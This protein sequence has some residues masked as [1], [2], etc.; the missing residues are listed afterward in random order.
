MIMCINKD[1]LLVNGV[2]KIKKMNITAIPSLVNLCEL[3]Q[4]RD[5]NRKQDL[6]NVYHK[7][8]NEYHALKPY[9]ILL[10]DATEALQEC[11]IY[12][13]LNMLVA[14]DEETEHLC[15]D[16]LKDVGKEYD[17]D[18][19]LVL[20]HE[21]SDALMERLRRLADCVEGVADKVGEFP[22]VAG[23]ADP[24]GHLGQRPAGDHANWRSRRLRRPGQRPGPL[25]GS[26]VCPGLPRERDL[27]AALLEHGLQRLPDV[28]GDAHLALG[29]GVDA[30]GQV[31][32]GI[33]EQV[34]DVHI[35][36]DGFLAV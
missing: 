5:T 17:E 26:R 32:L 12:V 15:R 19:D 14:I 35:E 24:L 10:R 13:E 4:T 33:A 7:I 6:L 23:L 25:L 16:A 8:R 28:L 2:D 22:A 1:K 31:Q 21:R 20:F 11:S 30:V 18:L 3:V 27:G 29:V 36:F 9:T 34:V